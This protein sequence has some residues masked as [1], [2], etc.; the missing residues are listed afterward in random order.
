[1]AQCR[2]FAQNKCPKGNKSTTPTWHPARRHLSEA[3]VAHGPPVRTVVDDRRPA[4]RGVNALHNAGGPA[5]RG[6]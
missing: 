6:A 2:D 4:D 5:V 3:P 1:M